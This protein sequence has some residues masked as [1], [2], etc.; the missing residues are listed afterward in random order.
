V[1]KDNVAVATPQAAANGERARPVANEK[2]R[3]LLI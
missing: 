2:K 3:V 1:A